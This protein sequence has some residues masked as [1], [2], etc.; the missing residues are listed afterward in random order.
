M[1]TA[2]ALLLLIIAAPAS[3]QTHPCDGTP[4][5]VEARP[6]IA[7]AI[8]FCNNGKDAEGNPVSIDGYKVMLDGALQ[9]SPGPLTKSATAN[10]AGLFYFETPKGFT[11]PDGNHTISVVLVNAKGGDGAPSAPFPLVSRTL[12]PGSPTSL[13]LVK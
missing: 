6:G 11:A 5:V 10:A 7:F 8:G 9:P 12:P 4:A 2:L 3:A 1:K 13:R